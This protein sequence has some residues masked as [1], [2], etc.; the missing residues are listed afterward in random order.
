MGTAK[1]K[2]LP[3]AEH[4]RIL[5]RYKSIKNIKLEPNHRHLN[6]RKY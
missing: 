2:D 3:R 4:N 6:L 5:P 1:H